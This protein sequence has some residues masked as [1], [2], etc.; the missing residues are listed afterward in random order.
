LSLYVDFDS[1]DNEFYGTD[2]IAAVL[3]LEDL[4]ANPDYEGEYSGIQDELDRYVLL[5]DTMMEVMG[6]EAD[7]I[8]DVSIVSYDYYSTSYAHE[9]AELQHNLDVD[10]GWMFFDYEAWKA[11]H[12]GEFNEFTWEGIV[13]LAS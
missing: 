13:F 2:V 6:A 5:R 10:N 3:T 9:Q 11:Y 4:L 7:K 1:Y 8:H 12:L